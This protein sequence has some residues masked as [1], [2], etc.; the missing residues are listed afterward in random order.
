MQHRQCSP[1][2]PGVKKKK[3]PVWVLLLTQVCFWLPF[4]NIFDKRG[5]GGGRRARRRHG[6]HQRRGQPRTHRGEE[7]ILH[8]DCRGSR[9]SSLTPLHSPRT[10]PF[11]LCVSLSFF[12]LFVTLLI[13]LTAILRPPVVKKEPS[14]GPLTG[15]SNCPPNR[16]SN[17]HPS[18][19]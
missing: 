11:S 6:H 8:L 17:L 5:E 10:S 13:S 2:A 18:C 12:F 9:A 4:R 1:L 7:G 19:H 15:S 3:S 14:G 16:P